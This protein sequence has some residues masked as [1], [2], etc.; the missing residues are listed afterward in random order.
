MRYAS[1]ITPTITVD[2]KI[3]IPKKCVFCNDEIN[4]S[5]IMAFNIKDNSVGPVCID[6]RKNLT[7]KHA[8]AEMI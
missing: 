8:M 3:S 4:Y 1:D 5:T 7:R 6:C 2:G